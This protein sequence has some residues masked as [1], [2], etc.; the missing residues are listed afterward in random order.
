MARLDS[1]AMRTLPYSVD[2]NSFGSK[3]L[4][5]SCSKHLVY[6]SISA[7]KFNETHH[8]KYEEEM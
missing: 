2:V 4:V 6:E 1:I 3:V 8:A 5:S 7:V